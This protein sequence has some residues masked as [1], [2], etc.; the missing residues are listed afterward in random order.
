MVLVEQVSLVLQACWAFPVVELL[1]QGPVV[2]CVWFQVFLVF[3]ACRVWFPV[4]P[5]GR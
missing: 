2:Q 3:Q 1:C 4:F 5:S